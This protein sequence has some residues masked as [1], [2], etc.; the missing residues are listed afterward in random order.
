M[1]AA[2]GGLAAFLGVQGCMVGP[3]YAPP[4]LVMPDSWHVALVD[5]IEA[6]QADP[7]AW[8]RNF[9]DEM[10]VELV[11]LAEER[12]LDLRSAVSSIRE[13]R[14]EYG[15][16]A[17]DLYPQVS[18]D[19]SAE[20]S[21]GNSRTPNLTNTGI[22]YEDQAYDLGLDL[23]WEVDLWGKVRRSVEA[24]EASVQ[25]QVEYWRDILV[26]V[27][28]EVAMSY[29]SAR[30]YQLQIQALAESIGSLEATLELVQQKF[31]A[32]VG[33]EISVAEAQASLAE[34]VARM[35]ALVE[36]KATAIN[37]LSVLVGE[38]PGPLRDRLAEV[39]PVP[40]PPAE[41]GVGI[42]ADV[43]R[44]RPDI[45]QAERRLAEATAYVGVAEAALLPSLKIQG[46]GGFSSNQFNDW[47]NSSNLGGLLG[48]TV[49]WP[50]FTAG[51][52]ESVVDVRDEQA[53]QALYAYES[54]VLNAIGDVE[55]ALIS[56]LQALQARRDLNATVAAYDRV[57]SLAEERYATGVDSLDTLLYNERLLMSARQDLAVAEGQ[58][59]TNA[60]MLYKA[61]GGGWEIVP[62]GTEGRETV[63]AEESKNEHTEVSG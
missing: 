29:I 13:A 12:N 39:Q 41:I 42:P 47:F 23:G 2:M 49:S 57:V 58:V 56:Y 10:L 60:V 46:S 50:F 22:E 3:D 15:I 35:P 11:T 7:G 26:S 51:R 59:S 14:A 4:Q 63:A 20:F 44:R 43:I 55:N 54:T 9:E 53:K 21:S 24:A 6:E 32:G 25:Y 18:L 34:A 38:T 1:A 31:D 19:T 30:S 36:G 17:S 5:G 16:A 37:R 33:N 40:Q 45:R 27:R 61:L 48:I 8:W 28:A 52:L 62:E